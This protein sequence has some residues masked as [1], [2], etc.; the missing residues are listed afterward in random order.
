MME[1]VPKLRRHHNKYLTTC[2]PFII[3][4]EKKHCLCFHCTRL[5]QL[6]KYQAFIVC[7]F[8][9]MLSPLTRTAVATSYFLLGIYLLSIALTIT[10]MHFSF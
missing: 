4:I 5:S 1:E 6:L 8:I 9:C 7:I 10:L 2:L 3:L